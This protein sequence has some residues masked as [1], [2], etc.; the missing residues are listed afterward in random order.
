MTRPTRRAGRA[1]PA[2]V[3]P[4]NPCGP[5]GAALAHVMFTTLGWS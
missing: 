1:E 2:N 5:V 4:T 3:H